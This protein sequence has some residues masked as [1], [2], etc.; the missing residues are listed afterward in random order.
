MV[1]GIGSGLTYPLVHVFFKARLVPA[2][3]ASKMHLSSKQMSHAIA[4]S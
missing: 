4:I 1:M 2:N 3:G